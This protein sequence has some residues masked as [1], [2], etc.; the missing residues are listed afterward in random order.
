MSSE[1]RAM[2]TP[3]QALREWRAASRAVDESLRAL[4]YA[5]LE[6]TDALGLAALAQAAV[7]AAQGALERAQQVEHAA[8]ATVEASEAELARRRDAIA[9]AGEAEEAAHERHKESAD[10]AY[11]RLGYPKREQD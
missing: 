2:P 7:E 9:S 1:K 10:R 8:R 5:E 3:E 6:R 11:E 4:S